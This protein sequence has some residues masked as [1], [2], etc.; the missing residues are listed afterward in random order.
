MNVLK[1]QFCLNWY[2]VTNFHI[3]IYIFRMMV[4]FLIF[5]VFISNFSI[6]HY[7]P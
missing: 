5:F 7:I 2:L 1:C 4:S 3:K 6:M